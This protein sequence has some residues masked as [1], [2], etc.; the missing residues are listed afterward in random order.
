MS[1]ENIIIIPENEEEALNRVEFRLKQNVLALFPGTTCFYPSV[2]MSQPSR[3]ITN[4]YHY[5]NHYP[6]HNNTYFY[7]VKKLKIIY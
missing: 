6:Y 4:P 7:S 2:V 3:V 1:E 5:H